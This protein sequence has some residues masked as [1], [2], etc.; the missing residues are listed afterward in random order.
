MGKTSHAYRKSYLLEYCTAMFASFLVFFLMIFVAQLGD[1]TARTT[2]LYWLKR[3]TSSGDPTQQG[4]RNQVRGAVPERFLPPVFTSS[5]CSGNRPIFRDCG[6]ASD[7]PARGC[8]QSHP[9]LASPRMFTIN[10]L[11]PHFVYYIDIRV[12]F[13]RKV[14]RAFTSPVREILFE[15]KLEL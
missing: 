6:D 8:F 13:L 2:F 7:A 11:S 3:V 9:F 15:G 1:A 12:Y 10:S 14:E 4:G 5:S